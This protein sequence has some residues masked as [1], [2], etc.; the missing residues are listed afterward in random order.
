MDRSKL[1]S[2]YNNFWLKYSSA[3]PDNVSYEPL[4][5]SP[6]T[7][8]QLNKHEFEILISLDFRRLKYKSSSNR[9]PDTAIRIR[10]S[11]HCIYDQKDNSKL[12]QSNVRVNYFRTEETSYKTTLSLIE[13]LHYDYE[14]NSDSLRNHPIFHCQSCNDYIDGQF[15][16]R[17]CNFKKIKT[18]VHQQLRIPTAN[19]DMI[20]VL[21]SI[22]ADHFTVDEFKKIL[23]VYD[24][25]NW[26]NVFPHISHHGR[27]SP[28]DCYRSRAWYIGE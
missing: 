8:K 19:M 2:L 12:T 10:G 17:Q 28:S 11:K 20:S 18:I 1:A 27:F 3:I 25:D 22:A 24:D 6:F 5:D 15:F 16:G 14:I 13:S 4:K 21:L 26:H 23:K 9:T 7:V